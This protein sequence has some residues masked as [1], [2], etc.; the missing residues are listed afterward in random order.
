MTIGMYNNELNSDREAELLRLG[1]GID[2][3]GKSY[4][5]FPPYEPEKDTA[6]HIGLSAALDLLY[7]SKLLPCPFCGGEAELVKGESGFTDIQ[8]RCLGCGAQ[9]QN[10]DIDNAHLDGV[11][12]KN[13]MNDADTLKFNVTNVTKA[14]NSRYKVKPQAEDNT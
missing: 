4:T 13:T 11:S 5:I 8:I 9:T 3:N 7:G 14:W 1:R 2:A 12:E 10:F 6:P